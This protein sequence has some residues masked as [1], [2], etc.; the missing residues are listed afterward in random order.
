[1][2]SLIQKVRFRSLNF[3]EPVKLLYYPS[4]LQVEQL[5]NGNI[6]ISFRE[7]NNEHILFFDAQGDQIDGIISRP[8]N[9][10]YLD[11]TPTSDDGFV[12]VGQ[13]HLYE[14]GEFSPYISAHFY[15]SEGE[16]D[17]SLLKLKKI[18]NASPRSISVHQLSN[19][20]I[21]IVWSEQ[22]NSNSNFRIHTQIFDTSGNAVSNMLT[23]TDIASEFSTWRSASTAILANGSTIIVW[24]ELDTEQNSDVYATIV[25]PDGDVKLSKTLLLDN[26]VGYYTS[27]LQVSAMSSGEFIVTWSGWNSDTGVNSQ[28]FD[29]D[30]NPVGAL[31]TVVDYTDQY[32]IP[33]DRSGGYIISPFAYEVE[34]EGIQFIWNESFDL[35][36]TTDRLRLLS[37]RVFNSD[38]TP[39]EIGQLNAAKND[40]IISSAHLLGNDINVDADD[41]LITDVSPTSTSGALLSINEDGDVV[42]TPNG[43]FDYLAEGETTTDTFTYTVSDT[44]GNTDTATVTV[45]I[46]GTNDAPVVSNPILNQTA[47]ETEKL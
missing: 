15:N 14:N 23:I 36:E 39:R 22:D 8:S 47:T 4:D 24:T 21:Q 19:D 11:T 28:K 42:F 26:I 29:T 17:Y 32:N 5:S 33:A 45:T 18:E 20:N 27:S 25:S 13:E 30:G 37:T 10:T 6:V 40:N 1:M 12:I 34:N 31:M 44:T 2:R 41:L 35:S 9:R 16:L 46:S 43:V 3:L 38:G 7:Q